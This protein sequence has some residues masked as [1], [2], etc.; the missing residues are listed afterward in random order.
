MFISDGLSYL[1]V[2]CPTDEDMDEYLNVLLT[3]E[4]EC[5]PS[6]LDMTSNGK[7]MMVT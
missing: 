5:N 2:I 6:D 4:G 1:P 7:I 3:P